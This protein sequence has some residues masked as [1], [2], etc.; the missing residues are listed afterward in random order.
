MSITSHISKLLLKFWGFKITG[1][2]PEIY[3][4][5][6]YAIIPHTSNWDFILGIL[7][8]SSMQLKL[9]FLAKDS[10]FKPLY[11]WVFRGLGGIPV[12]RSKS[13]NFVEA[14]LEIIESRD[15]IA[16]AI[17]PEGTRKKV[18]KL[19]SGFYW[20]AKKA[21]IPLILVMFDYGNKEVDFAPPFEFTENMEQDM[22]RIK[23]HFKGVAGKNKENS[24][25]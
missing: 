18:T 8:R 13:H 5:K 12:D 15:Q 19:K 17:A 21:N 9:Q 7:V 1:I 23:L 25:T 10:L 14:T 20:L 4:K 22:E 2:N 11:G 6:I 24:F 3:P 16:L